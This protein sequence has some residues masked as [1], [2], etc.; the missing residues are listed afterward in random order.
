[1]C[2]NYKEQLADSRWLRKKNEILERD[3]YT[4][5]K[6]GAKSHLNV[7]HLNY[8]KEK[9][10]WEYPKEQLITLCYNCHE[11]LHRKQ[12]SV[13]LNNI[14]RGDWYC[15]CF[16]EFNTYAI[17]FDIDHI[18]KTISLFGSN[19]GA[20]GS[21]WIYAIKHKDFLKKWSKIDIFEKD[22]DDDFIFAYSEYFLSGFMNAFSELMI[23]RASIYGIEGHFT[24]A[25]AQHY[26]PIYIQRND[27]FRSYCDINNIKYNY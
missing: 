24:L 23:G 1:M 20:W 19:E 8:E 15:G 22:I 27:E 7:H 4:C 6:C 13:L 18:T 5:Q 10:A 26:L 25:Y 2:F 16:G 9:L 17:I 3:N 14:K 21:G 12:N 11:D